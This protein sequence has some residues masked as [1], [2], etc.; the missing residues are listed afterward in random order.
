MWGYVTDSGAAACF[1][2]SLDLAGAFAAGETRFA[3]AEIM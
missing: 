2:P 3:H 1:T